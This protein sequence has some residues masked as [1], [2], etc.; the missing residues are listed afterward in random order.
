MAGVTF[1]TALAEPT[2]APPRRWVGLL[3]LASFGMWAGFYGPIQVLLAEPV[4]AR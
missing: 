3:S 2:A 4:E 1:V